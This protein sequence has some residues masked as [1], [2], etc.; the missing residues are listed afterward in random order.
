[1]KTLGV[2][3]GLGPETTAEFYM[4][5]IFSS[6]E[7]NKSA[8]PPIMIWSVPLDYSIERDL[9]E[10]DS[11]TERYIPYLLDAAQRLEKA[12]VD[13]IVMPCNS[14]HIHIDQIRKAVQIPVLSIIEETVSFLKSKS[15]RE[16]GILA[17]STTINSKLYENKLNEADIKLIV[18][19][20]K[21]QNMV[22]SIISSLVLS[23]HSEEDKKN[24]LKLLDEFKQKD[25]KN[26]ILA[27]TDLQL[28]ITEYEGINVYD[29]MKIL[30]DS[31]VKNI[32]N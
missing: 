23:K 5:T 9:I 11:G 10:L 15:I 29:T 2:I 31:S 1:M 28:L 24:I 32:L 21:S 22:N 14:L 7:I 16:V 12:G 19:D 30:V 13:F 26:V 25:I 18:P 4:D 17:T 3:G 27:C 8:R 20:M 6:F